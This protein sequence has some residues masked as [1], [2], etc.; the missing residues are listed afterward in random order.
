MS[1]GRFA[2]LEI[3]SALLP[4]CC[5][6]DLPVVAHEAADALDGAS[7]DGKRQAQRCRPVCFEV[8]CELPRDDHARA[9]GATSASL[10]PVRPAQGNRKPVRSRPILTYVP[11]VTPY[12]F[13]HIEDAYNACHIAEPMLA[14]ALPQ[15]R[16]AVPPPSEQ[17]AR[18]GACTFSAAVFRPPCGSCGGGSHS[19]KHSNDGRE[20]AAKRAAEQEKH[21]GPKRD[22]PY[23]QSVALKNT[24]T[25]RLN[26]RGGSDR[27]CLVLQ[28]DTANVITS[29]HPSFPTA[30]LPRSGAQH[31]GWPSYCFDCQPRLS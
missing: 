17:S 14:S 2:I 15:Y 24:V 7:A 25:L 27:A 26:R 13:D 4:H 11:L 16:P 22:V 19:E 10:F 12:V 5:C 6:G 8:V 28:D 30:S 3:R 23:H 1:F 18:D 20:D 31:Q 9:A 29:P 21:D